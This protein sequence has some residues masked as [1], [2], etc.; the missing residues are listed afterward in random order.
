MSSVLKRMYAKEGEHDWV[1]WE[2][3]VSVLSLTS[4]LP[5]FEQNVDD[6]FMDSKLPAHNAPVINRPQY[7]AIISRMNN[8]AC[9]AGTYSSL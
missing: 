4:S 5:G 8:A 6:S 1:I 7:N 2:R 3:G 9:H